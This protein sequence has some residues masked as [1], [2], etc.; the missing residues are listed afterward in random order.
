VRVMDFGL[1]RRAADT[2]VA[3]SGSLAGTAS[4]MAAEQL[5]GSAADARSDQFAF[6]V[7]LWEALYG[8]RPFAGN[9]MPELVTNVLDGNLLAAPRGRAVPGWLR[10]ACERGLARDPARRWPAMKDLLE[11]LERGQ[12]TAGRQR[13]V[14]AAAGVVLVVG[15]VLGMREVDARRRVAACEERGASIAEVWNDDARAEVEAAMLATEVSYARVSADKVMPWLDRQ[16]EEW[17][18]VRTEVCL[19][20]DV[21]GTRTA[22]AVERSLWCLDERRME[23]EALVT[24]LGRAD[25]GMVQRAVEAAASLPPVAPCEDATLLGRLPT[26]PVEHRERIREARAA[27]ARA[28]ALGH[29]GKHADAL[30]ATRD[31]LE[32]AQ[33]I[34]WPPLVAGALARESLM[35]TRTGSFAEAERIGAE[36][37]FTAANAGAWD[38]ATNAASQLVFI[39]GYELGRPA[40]G[41]A[42]SRHA[43]VALAHAG[44]P[45]GMREASRL[46]NL[47]SVR[48]ST[49]EYAEA[50]AL[51]ERA[52][53]IQEQLHASEGP[54]V[55]RTIGNLASVYATTA[56][57]AKSRELLVRALAID[58]EALGPNHPEV[59]NLLNNLA[60]VE[61]ATGDDAHAR[62]GYERARQIWED[63]F[64][65]NHPDVATSLVNLG[66]LE[67]DSGRHE[68]ARALYQRAATIREAVLPPDH[69]EIGKSLVN[70]GNVDTMTGNY[71]RAKDEYERGLAILEKALGRTHPDVA[72]ALT[73][74]GRV[75][76]HMGES[77]RAH[78]L[79]EEALAIDEKVLGPTHPGLAGTLI[80]LAEVALAERRFGD[81]V[82]FAERAL[83]LREQGVTTPLELADV[84]FALA[85]PLWEV[86][87][88]RDRALL[89]ARQARDAYRDA[90]V[91]GALKN[92]Q[93]WL[94]AHE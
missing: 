36:A 63:A 34:A 42:W 39:V 83:S 65:P 43:A 60:N 30:A 79:F 75:L 27:I 1:A 28:N 16:A 92:V 91:E 86:G 89:L 25:A 31:L 80:G 37:Y 93:R 38:V 17:K 61:A 62:A 58:E 77:A 46:L 15:G 48:F 22:D 13:F 68:E 70:L 88:E 67:H 94:D 7:A 56:D 6:C 82:A 44:D 24:E 14:V 45:A 4:Y 52:L 54:D 49:A 55:A 11:A 8:G 81:G 9:T 29:A 87:R 64:G 47:A 59:A 85:G 32:E 3:E 21:H 33:S 2:R 35:L 71:E 53:A 78:A 23:L 69:P 26:P 10:R 19:D 66:T 5:A 76:H 20:A 74:L 57:Y 72:S 73:N 51:F 41:D 12:A 40:D 90:K 18:R 50:Q 84:R